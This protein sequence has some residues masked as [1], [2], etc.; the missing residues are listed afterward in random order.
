MGSLVTDTP[1]QA[2]QQHL[3]RLQALYS[4]KAKPGD[5]EAEGPLFTA[6]LPLLEAELAPLQLGEPFGVGSTATIWKVHEKRGERQREYA[7]KFPRPRHGRL[8]AIIRVIR[9]ETARLSELNHQNVIKVYQWG[10]LAAQIA[11]ADYAF[12]YFLMDYLP[13]VDDFDKYIQKHLRRLSGEQII[14]YI[15]D[16]LTGLTFLHEQG[17]IH[18]DI[19]PSNLLIAD[20]IP[21]LITDLG[22][23]KNFLRQH[24][25]SDTEVVFTKEYAHPELIEKMQ[26]TPID[27]NAAAAVLRY[28]NLR[29]AYDLYSFGLTVQRIL[30]IVRADERTSSDTAS[31][32]TV[33]QWR[34]LALIAL[35]LLDGVTR[36]VSSDP[37]DSDVLPDFPRAEMQHIKYE[38]AGQALEDVERL[39]NLYDLE[40]EI[41]ELNPNARKYIQVPSVRVPDT[42]R[43]RALINHPALV[44]LMQV[45][46]LGFVSMIYPG[47]THSRFEHVLGTFGHCCETVRALWYDESNCLFRSLY[48]KKDLEA[49]LVAAL[50]HDV[51]QYPMAHDMA[52]ASSVFG[53]ERFTEAILRRQWPNG[54][55]SVDEVLRSEW[56]ITV[57]DILAI[58][59]ADAESPFRL[60]ILKSII[61]GPLDCDKVDYLKRDSIHTGVTFGV[62]LD[63]GRLYRNY[64]IVYKGV[65]KGNDVILDVAEIGV[66]ERALAAAQAVWRS[67][68]DMFRQVYWQHTVRVLK[69]MLM[70][71]VRRIAM[72]EH[73]D[74]ERWRRFR[75]RFYRF[76]L[77]PMAFYNPANISGLAN[78]AAATDAADDLVFANDDPPAP[79]VSRLQPSD[80]ALIDF[81]AEYAEPEEQAVLRM[82]RERRIYKRFAVVSWANE[83][84]RYDTIYNGF[85]ADRLR[86]HPES[87]ESSRKKC[88][89]E[90]LVNIEASTRNVP[91]MAA[92][93]Q[94]LRASTSEPILLID[95][96]VKALRHQDQNVSEGQE[97]LWYVSEGQ[98]EHVQE[99]RVVQFP[100][101]TASDIRVQQARFDREVGRIRALIHPAWYPLVRR[102][103]DPAGVVRL[104]A[105]Y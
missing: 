3:T 44:R 50:V 32:F 37:F 41:P 96:P 42:H 27:P 89:E 67:R 63:E 60:R 79:I 105:S 76:I 77:A 97:A 80:D 29:Q 101:P 16:I 11:G 74:T 7:L 28:E 58:T 75:L 14:S 82:L 53:H 86:E 78:D 68:R 81:L 104:I 47:A 92:R 48:S 30:T 26:A 49:V 35:R 69:A 72:R 71:A 93:F 19:K 8:D 18:C 4:S 5:F 99:Q 6:L 64:T 84:S 98:L 57:D 59:D 2:G 94:Q 17:I 36:R 62:A 34:Y 45:T 10:E 102:L 52:E 23:S 40:G 24:T 100:S 51:A 33:Y 88:E 15:R 66:M 103:V 91:E 61:N 25:G 85:S 54:V 70:F 46:Q 56:D 12:P 83:Q 21:A 31:R 38:S 95:V 55:P 43:V 20:G 90:L 9:S 22:Y 13:T 73:E 39:L 1:T 65:T 87:I